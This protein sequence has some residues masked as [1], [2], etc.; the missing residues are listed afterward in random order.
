MKRGVKMKIT[1]EGHACFTVFANDTTVMI[2]PF[3]TGN[4]ACKKQ[5][6]EFHPDLILITHG[7]GDHLGDALALARRSG[8]TIA[9][10][11]DLLNVL[12]TEGINTIAF[13]LG[14]SCNFNG[15]HITMVPAWHGNSVQTDKGVVG[16]GLACGYVI[17]SGEGCIYHAGDTAL[18]GDMEK[19]LQDYHIDVAMLPIGDFYTMGPKDAVTAARWLKAKVVI[20]MHYNTF[21]IIS[22]DVGAFLSELKMRTDS[23]GVALAPGESFDY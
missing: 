2:D 16:C 6:S 10:Q 14:G 4:P 5:L 23:Q 17:T 1:F 7:H 19:I 8:A 3:I 15:L 20:P 22:Q 11:V 12:D 21:P 18:F 9:A 13:N